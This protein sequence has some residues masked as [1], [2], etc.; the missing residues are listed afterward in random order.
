MEVETW[1]LAEGVSG[2]KAAAISH[3]ISRT[4][5]YCECGF[6]GTETDITASII[7]TPLGQIDLVRFFGNDIYWAD[8]RIEHVRKVKADDFIFYLPRDCIA[9]IQQ[10]GRT[11]RFGAGRIGFINTRHAY[12]GKLESAGRGSFEST[13]LI[14]PGPILRSRFPGIDDLA[15][16]A[17]EIGQ[18]LSGIFSAYI[19]AIDNA[20]CELTSPQHLALSNILLETICAVTD[21]AIR[22]HKLGPSRVPSTQRAL[23]RIQT[24]AL[25]HLTDPDLSVAMIATSLNMSPRYVHSAFENTQWT[26]KSWIRH[27]RLLECRKAIRSPSLKGRTLTEIAFSWGFSDFSHFSRR[28]KEKFGCSPKDDRVPA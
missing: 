12:R 23:E 15:A 2:S 13:H 8:R 5:G 14:V 22:N 24:F 27:R 26:A 28:Y 10:D 11:A 25:A 21:Y 7:R 16:R 3:A 4:F 18:S 6:E 19:A 9:T 17:I 1:Q 20:D